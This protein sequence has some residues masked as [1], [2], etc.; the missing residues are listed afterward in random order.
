[1]GQVASDC[2]CVVLFC[3][4]AR[5]FVAPRQHA[6]P[7]PPLPPSHQSLPLP[8]PTPH[9]PPP[10]YPVHVQDLEPP[11]SSFYSPFL[12]DFTASPTALLSPLGQDT[13]SSR[14]SLF[15]RQNGGDWELLPLTVAD[16][17][18]SSLEDGPHV[19]EVRAVD[20]VG[21]VQPPPYDVRATVVDQVAPVVR[22]G[23]ITFNTMVDYWTETNA[24]YHTLCLN[25]TDATPWVVALSWTLTGKPGIDGTVSSEVDAT[26]WEEGTLGL[27]NVSAQMCMDVTPTDQGLAQVW[28]CCVFPAFPFVLVIRAWFAGLACCRCSWRGQDYVVFVLQIALHCP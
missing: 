22:L 11:T 16:L 7:T 26:S 20:A 24:F 5:L 2:E 4:E 28:L 9:P 10:T 21:N 19:F 13:L 23:A 25:V 12:P 15:L 18:Y 1:V 8:P 27:K 3:S 14:V 6:S 17:D